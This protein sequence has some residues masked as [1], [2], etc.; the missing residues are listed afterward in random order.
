MDSQFIGNVESLAHNFDYFDALILL[1]STGRVVSAHIHDNN[2]ASGS[3]PHYSD[4]HG[5]FGTGT[6]PIEKS[7]SVLVK[8]S[9]ANLIDEAASEPVKNLE[10]LK[11]MVSEQN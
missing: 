8:K 11:N 1:I 10:M 2:S 6:V 3:S 9:S 7:I 4:D 5:S